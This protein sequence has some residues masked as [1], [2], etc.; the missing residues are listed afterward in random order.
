[1][2]SPVIRN[3]EGIEE[4][5]V[6]WP[7]AQRVLPPGMTA[8]LRVRNEA[9]SLPW[10]LPRLLRSV[11]HVVLIDNCS[12][13]GTA[14]VGAEV[15]MKNDASDRISIVEY[16]FE[17][18]RCGPEH[19]ETPADSVHSLTHFYNWSFS[20]VQTRYSLKWDGDMVLTPE[21]ASMLRDLGWQISAVETVVLFQHHP[22][23]I[24][25]PQVAY[26]DLKLR[27]VEPWIYPMGPESIYLKGFDWEIRSHPA[28]AE[29]ITMPPG[30]CFELKW[31]DTDEFAHWTSI[32]AFHPERSPRKVREYDVFTKLRA[33]LYAELEP[34]FL[35]RV[36]APA[37]VHV[38]DHVAHR[39]LAE[40]LAA[41]TR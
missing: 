1:M 32:E 29:R 38:I 21:G 40:A 11:D 9:R 14:T 4:F 23:Y 17:V 39:G 12:D 31:L 26:L 18:S 35:Y 25:S 7:W 5:D 6:T 15:A 13:D 16:P 30:L 8:V 37:G 27:N 24:E 28:E 2:I 34:D 36:E 22:L 3:R 20:Q 10:V 41:V 33:G 19:L